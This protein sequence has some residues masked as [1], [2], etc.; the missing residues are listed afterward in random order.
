MMSEPGL[1]PLQILILKELATLQPAWTLTGGGALSLCYLSQRETRDL[2]LFFHGQHRLG[3]AT[4]AVRSRLGEAGLQVTSIQTSPTFARLRV[5]QAGLVTVVDLVAEPVPC[6]EPPCTYKVEEVEILV[7]TPFEILVN[8]LTALLSRSEL[9]DLSDVRQLLLQGLDLDKALDA[10][11]TKDGGFSALTLA[12]VLQ[13]LSVPHLA[14]GLTLDPGAT[15]TLVEFK[16][17]LIR[18]LLEGCRPEV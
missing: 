14:Q 11:P 15:Q 5:A 4:E 1:G 12:W 8:K 18:R 3:G 16:E 2:D 17:I 9:R 13:G 7:D 10:A 6:V